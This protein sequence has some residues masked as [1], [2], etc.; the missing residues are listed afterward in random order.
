MDI[1]WFLMMYILEI[2]DGTNGHSDILTML[3]PCV[4]ALEQMVHLLQTIAC[5]E[6]IRPLIPEGNFDIWD[7]NLPVHS[8]YCMTYNEIT[9]F[10]MRLR[11]P[12]TLMCANRCNFFIF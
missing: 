11:M 10:N 6:V 3:V 5:T 12:L 1:R 7:T 4:G 8:L 2:L 9:E